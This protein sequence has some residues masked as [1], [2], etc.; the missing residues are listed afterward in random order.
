MEKC[1]AETTAEK[2]RATK[3]QTKLQT[4]FKSPISIQGAGEI[5]GKS[6]QLPL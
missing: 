3:C 5:S 6:I 4:C 1:T 2:T